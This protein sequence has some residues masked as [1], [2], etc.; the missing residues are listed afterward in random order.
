MNVLSQEKRHQIEA[1][2]QLGW[3]V[4]RIALATETG[5]ETVGSYLRAA[6]IGLK[7]PGRPS[8]KPA[9]SG[10]N[11]ITDSVA[12]AEPKPAISTGNPVTGSGAP[13]APGPAS[14][15]EP[16][17]E[18]IEEALSRGRTAT[19]IWQDLKD[20]GFSG[21]YQS[22]RRFV[23]RLGLRAPLQARCVIVTAPGEEAQVDWGTGPTVRDPATGQYRRTRL[24]V[25]TLG[26]SR[27]S[28]RFVAWKSGQRVWTELHERA[29][30][31]LGGAPRTVVLDNLK[32]GVAEAH[33]YDPGLNP[34]YRD[35]LKHHGVVAL[36]A[37]VRPTAKGNARRSLAMSATSAVS[38]AT[39]EPPA[40]IAI[41]TVALAM[42]GASF[43][44]SPTIAT[45]LFDLASSAMAATFSSGSRSPRAART[46]SLTVQSIVTFW[47][48]VS[49]SERATSL[50]FRRPRKSEGKT[51]A[52]ALT[53]T[54]ATRAPSRSSTMST[55]VPSLSRK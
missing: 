25:F 5:R 43:T 38:R 48:T 29:F 46:L 21:G 23:E 14:Y 13:L 53:S 4:R 45:R 28:V 17:R 20:D 47:R 10:E 1:L 16:Y 9:I 22:V 37:R 51:V 54:P 50:S 7:P 27:K 6:G 18:R 44:P 19:S 12:V 52:A 32:E 36:P 15:C 42:A 11:P 39:S 55:S 26:C 41:P 33:W 31:R 30:R 3:S 34:L 49:T 2:G 8:S 24:F 40:P 35:V